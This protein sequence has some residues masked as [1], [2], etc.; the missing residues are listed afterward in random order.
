MPKTTKKRRHIKLLNIII[1]RKIYSI[2]IKSFNALIKMNN[3]FKIN[4]KINLKIKQ[5]NNIGLR[6]A[7][8]M[9]H[10]MPKKNG[11]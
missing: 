7:L 8:I 11:F 4:I 1:K 9:N 2:G 10:K 6:L 3:K 5:N